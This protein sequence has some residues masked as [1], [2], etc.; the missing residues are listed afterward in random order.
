MIYDIYKFFKDESM[1]K[2]T[3]KAFYDSVKETL[4]RSRSFILEICKSGVLT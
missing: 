1:L 2:K 3:S 4:G